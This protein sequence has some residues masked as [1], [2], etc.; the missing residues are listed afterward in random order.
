MLTKR[1]P[2]GWH[3]GL[4]NEIYESTEGVNYE[5]TG[6]EPDYRIDYVK[7]G[8]LFYEQLLNE[9]ESGDQAIDKAIELG[10]KQSTGF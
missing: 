9:P 5:K 10:K 3:Y 4:S 8:V 6:I 2:N 7:N 1:L